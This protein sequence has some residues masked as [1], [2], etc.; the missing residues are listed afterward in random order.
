MGRRA[1]RLGANTEAGHRP[2]QSAKAGAGDCIGLSLFS[3]MPEF[4]AGCY[5]DD[6]GAFSEW[7]SLPAE[8]TDMT[9]DYARLD[10]N[11]DCL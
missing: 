3:Y 9:T 4:Q 7:Y 6:F 11:A 1:E 10:R 5:K 2:A 8:M